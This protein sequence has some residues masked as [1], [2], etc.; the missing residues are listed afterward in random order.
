MERSIVRGA[1]RRHRPDVSHDRCGKLARL[2]AFGSLEGLERDDNNSAVTFPRVT[3]ERASQLVSQPASRRTASRERILRLAFGIRFLGR[4]G[5]SHGQV[6]QE[7]GSPADK[8]VIRGRR[9]SS[10]VN[11][12]RITVEG[13]PSLVIGNSVTRS[14]LARPRST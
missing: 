10:S 9:V 13:T 8:F 1:G 5:F 7:S 14:K 3:S 2:L 4:P 11:I 12:D 6:Y